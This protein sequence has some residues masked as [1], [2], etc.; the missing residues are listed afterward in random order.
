M[1]VSGSDLVLTDYDFVAKIGEPIAAP[2]TVLYCSPSYQEKRVASPS[3]DIYALA[4]SF[5]HVVFE[6]EPFEYGG[7]QA[8]E[9]GLNWEGLNRAEFPLLAAF[10]DK[11]THRDP[12]QRFGSVAD[13]LFALRVSQPVGSQ[14]GRETEERESPDLA[15]PMPSNVEEGERAELHE[16]QVE[17]LLSLL[18]SYPGSR[19]GNRETRGL[20]TDFAAQTYVETNLEETLYRDIP[21]RRVRLV[22]LCGNAGD[23]KTAL[24]QH[25]AARLGLGKHFSS[26]RILRRTDG[27]WSDCTYESR[28]IGRVAGT[29]RRR[30]SRRVPG[31]VPRR[32]AGRGYRAPTGDQRRSFAGVDRG[33]WS[34]VEA[35]RKR[36]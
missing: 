24:L 23:G 1:I 3:D 22:I 15:G 33:E 5:F 9:R 27:R 8:K 13:A 25:L 20:D 21:E 17:W 16:Q 6:K 36:H 19:W 30:A 10:L 14:T 12:E 29:L 31:T 2:G 28:R 35:E 18:Q 11:A 7:V 34:R 4:A 26:E 32:P